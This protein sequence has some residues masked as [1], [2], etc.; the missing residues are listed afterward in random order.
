MEGCIA[1]LWLPR[2]GSGACF[3]ALLGGPETGRWQIAPAGPVQ[4]VRRRY[5]EGTMVLET[6]YETVDGSV[7]VVDAM[8]MRTPRPDVSRVVVG[9][10]G[11]VRMRMELVIRFDYGSVVPS[12]HPPHPR[13][14]ST[15][16][17]H[18]PPLPT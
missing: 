17:P 16:P 4:S 9:T 12:G 6:E 1:W 15:S 13:P 11:V 14:H 3:A 7:T 10:R 2:L 18:P 8:P 5:R